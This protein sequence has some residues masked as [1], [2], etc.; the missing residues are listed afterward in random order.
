MLSDYHLGADVAFF[1]ARPAISW[2]V[3]AH[4]EKL[5]RE[6]SDS[7]RTQAFKQQRYVEAAT[8]AMSPIVKT[9]L[10]TLPSKVIYHV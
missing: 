9:I 7:K 6:N 1:L 8:I 10:T 4:Y 5:R 2:S 3:A